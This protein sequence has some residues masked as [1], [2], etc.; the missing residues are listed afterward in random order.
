MT[1]ES[2][3]GSKAA[4]AVAVTATTAALA[5]GVCCVLPF[6]IPAAVLGSA[7]GVLAWFAEAYRW[8][9]PVALIAVTSGWAWVGYQSWLTHR[10]PAPSTLLAMTIATIMMAAAWIWPMFEPTIIA[11][12]DR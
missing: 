9:T 12:V 2:G 3:S 1:A 5:C 6:A 4:G 11:F 7:G 10:F 8:L